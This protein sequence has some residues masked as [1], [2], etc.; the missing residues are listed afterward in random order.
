MS[1]IKMTKAL[2]AEAGLY[3]WSEG[4]GQEIEIV[5]VDVFRGWLAVDRI[6]SGYFTVSRLGGY[7]AKVDQ[8]IFEFED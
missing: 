7:W 5:E 8:S 6:E 1:K 3:Y 4:Q 2:P